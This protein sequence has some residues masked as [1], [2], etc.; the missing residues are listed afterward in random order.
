MVYNYDWSSTSLGPIDRWDPAI[1]N[2]MNLILNTEF[3][4]C[5]FINPPDWILIYNKESSQLK[6]HY[7][8]INI[9]EFT[10]ELASDFKNMAKTLG[11]DYIIDIPNPDEFN[12]AV[13]DKVYLDSDMYET[14]VL[15]LCSNAFKHTW[16]GQITI[17]LYLDYKDNRKMIVLEVSDT[18]VGIPEIALPNIFRR[19]YRVES[20]ESRSHEGT[21]IGLSLVKELITHHG[22]DITVSSVVNQGTTFR[23]W[24]PIGCDHLLTNQIHSNNMEIQMNHG[25]EIYTNRQLY[26]EESSLWIKNKEPGTQDVMMDQ[27]PTDNHISHTDKILMK[28]NKK[29]KIYRTY[30]TDLLSEFEIYRARDGKDA[31]RVLKTL[32]KLPDLIISVKFIVIKLNIDIMMPNMDGYELLDV[33]RSDLKTLMIPVILLSAKAGETSKIK[34]LDKG[35]DDYLVK[36]FS[37]QELI[38]RIRANIELSLVRRKIF[39]HRYKQEDTKQLLISITNTIISKLDLNETLLYTA[40]EIYRRLPCERI[41]IIS[42]GQSK[43]NKI[44][45]SGEEE[46]P[47]YLTPVANP[48]LEI[49]DNTKSNLQTFTKLQENLNTNSGVDISLDVYCDDICK[50]VSIL[51]VEILLDNENWGWIKVHRSPNSIW[52]DSEI[53]FLQQISNQLNMA[54]KYTRLLKENREKE[55]QIKAAE[56]ASNAKSQILANTSHGILLL[57]FYLLLKLFNLLINSNLVLELRTPLNAVVGIASSFESIKL[58]TDQRDML[59]IISNAS[60]VVLSIVNDILNV[61]KLGAKKIILVN[62]TFD[63]LELLDG[64]IDTFGKQAGSKKIELI[65]N[66]EVDMLPRYVKSDPERVKFTNEGEIVLTISMKPREFI[67]ENEVNLTSDQVIKKEVLCLELCDTGIGINPEYIQHVWKSF[68]Q[69]DMLITRKQDGVGLGLSICKSLVEINGGEI[70]AESQLG[71]GSTFS[72]T[73]NVELL[74]MMSLSRVSQFNEQIS[75]LL[76]CAVRKKR[77]LIIHSVESVRNRNSLLKYLKRVEKVD[78]FD[79]FD[80]GIRAAKSYKKLYQRVYDIVFISLYENN[81]EEAMNAVLELKELDKYNSLAIIFIVFPSDEGI[82]LAS[83]LIELIEKVLTFVIYA[84]ITWNKLISQFKHMKIIN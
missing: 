4:I 51:S 81:K 34:G 15:N 79:T 28:D 8:E 22:G 31:L 71:K 44:I 23:C 65:V 21:G 78:A 77:I 83:E 19:F 11:L 13:G 26:L 82:K 73:W 52:S 1:K 43:N 10:Q 74:S 84:P 50:N 41:F 53:E 30:L 17:R 47:E 68:S 27:F 12:R 48:F 40:R 49:G 2:L 62:R 3:P 57:L 6:V 72:F 75:Y 20:Q 56:I 9:A 76:P 18:G 67:G 63:L 66:C 59:S 61:A 42:N 54:I 5:V 45:V 33:L 14:I 38:I 58:A 46:G 69:G 80:K 39:F 60:D 37:N 29:Y 32:N 35:A 36:P 55:I 64:T 70:K 16:S 24:F 25:Q 7:R